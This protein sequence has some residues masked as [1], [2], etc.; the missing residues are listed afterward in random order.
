MDQI[1][2]RGKHA[3]VIGGSIAGILAARALARHYD[4]VTIL[5]RDDFGRSQW[6]RPGVP[7]G[8]HGHALLLSGIRAIEELFPGSHTGLVEAG[9]VPVDFTEDFRF[10]HF[11]VWKAR[12]G[13]NLRGTLQSRSLL[14]RYLRQRLTSFSNVELRGGCS[15]EALVPSTRLDRI[16][17]V[18]V[19][20]AR[21]RSEIVDADLVVDA[22]GQGSRTPRWLADL[23]YAPPETLQVPIN[24]GYA[25]QIYRPPVESRDWFG[26]VV[27]PRAPQG[28]R[29]GY[30]FAIED[31]LWQV[32]LSGYMGDHP[33]PDTAGFQSFA[34]SLAR[35]D[36]ADNLKDATPASEIWRFCFPAATWRRYDRL[37]RFPDGLVVLGDAVCRL[38]PT[39][40]HGMSAAAKSA[41]LLERCLSTG[42]I[43]EFRK[44]LYWILLEPWLIISS[45]AYR[46]RGI[47]G[48]RRPVH[49]LMQWFA[50]NIYELSATSKE[51]HTLSFEVMHLDKRIPALLRP[52]VL[53]QV[54]RNSCRTLFHGNL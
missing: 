28:H 43:Q 25:T 34:R 5:E 29:A 31:G 50:G 46:H 51:V 53:G 33:A 41:V 49:W 7:Q 2:V 38:D 27:Y 13:S 3:L 40:A 16:K 24:L 36:I 10:F 30:I 15:A 23:G 11:G 44:R 39:Y 52:S 14:E 45:E 6:P 21:E 26:L 54:L 8:S 35:A 22:G 9:A 1:E 32:T 20:G 48:R 37:N 4:R 12:H 18:R 47:Q 17:G 42:S 19:R